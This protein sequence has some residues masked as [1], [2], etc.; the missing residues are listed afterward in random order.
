MKQLTI[1]FL[2]LGLIGG[3]IARSIRKNFPSCRIIV[4][5]RRINEDLLQG[6]KDG[7]ISDITYAIDAHFSE[8]DIIFLCAP[9]LQNIQ[10]LEQLKPLINKTCII[11]D[12]GS[13][14]GNI[15]K[16]VER[17][18]L[19][20]QFIGGHPMAG[21]EK[22]GF[23][24]SSEDLLQDS[25]YLLTPCKTTAEEK[26]L[27]L[28]K[29]L[30]GTGAIFATV[31]AG[32]HDD[33]TAAISHVPHIVAASLVN[34]VREND[35]SNELMKTFAAGGFKDIT[36]IASSSPEMWESI[37]LSNADS[38]D[39]FLSLMIDELT[40]MRSY[41]ANEQGTE[42]NRFFAS[43]REYRDSIH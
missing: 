36:R 20:S 23:A 15:H 38:I 26:I 32:L 30:S 4:Y 19:E 43:S 42:I 34:M 24:N 3:S 5:S 41:I 14:K 11:T 9:V 10:F 22:T 40:K 29:I 12:V 18:E 28:K 17:L 27:F 39:H 2:G 31:D 6:K 7:I 16:E 13:V 35:T 1:G 33:I 25:F 21:S 8:C 37:C